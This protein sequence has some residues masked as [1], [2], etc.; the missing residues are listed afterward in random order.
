MSREKIVAKTLELLQEMRA[1]ELSMHK[2]AKALGIGT[3]TLY[4]YFE[5]REALLQAASEQV[6][7]EVDLSAAAAATDWQ[8]GLREWASAIREVF[9][10]NAEVV[11]LIRSY[12]S[13]PYSWFELE[14]RL[15]DLLAGIGLTDKPLRDA[16]RWAAREVIGAILLELNMR[17]ISMAHQR[18]AVELLVGRLSSAAQD[19]LRRWPD[20][21]DEYV[22][23]D[24]N[25]AYTISRVIDAMDALSKRSGH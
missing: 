7:L 5:N 21:F 20:Y 24:R 1:E 17:R 23:H 8:T 18:E 2:L 4:V 3:M 9:I 16:T 12:T 11:E 13:V 15:V 25:F 19:I 10:S 6:L 22:D 14:V